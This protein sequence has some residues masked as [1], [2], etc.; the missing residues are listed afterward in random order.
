[1]EKNANEKVSL[2]CPQCGGITERTEDGFSCPFC[3]FVEQRRQTMAQ[4]EQDFSKRLASARE[5]GRI[6]AQEEHAY[7]RSEAAKEQRL[8]KQRRLRARTIVIWTCIIL[9]IIA[10]IVMCIVEDLH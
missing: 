3:G 4:E 10:T 9:L 1:M 7:E 6:R 8:R 5:A 2:L